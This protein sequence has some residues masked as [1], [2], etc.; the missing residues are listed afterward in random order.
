MSHSIFGTFVTTPLYNG[1][2]L[3]MQALPW[4]DLGVIVIVF[5]CVIRL[6][7]FPIAQKSVRTQLMVQKLQPEMDAIKEKYK[8]DKQEQAV[9]MMELYRNNK[10]N[11]FSN[12]LFLFIQIPIIFGLYFMVLRAGF[13]AIDPTFLYSFVDAP[14]HINTMFLGLVDVTVRSIPI[15][16]LAG[17]SQFFQAKLMRVP[18]TKKDTKPSFGN[19]FSKSLQFQMKYIFP[20]VI[21]F[22]A[23]ALPASV[24]LYWTTS[25]LFSIG[26]EWWTRKK[27][28][29]E[30]QQPTTNN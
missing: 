19:E 23:S 13:P 16:I 18:E 2:V 28:T 6:I 9:K 24:A 15:A 4:A 22:I 30:N 27:I 25:N 10:V 21:V 1:I 14:S 5:T 11:P 12:I 26:Q 7:L 20:V 8:N 17:V 29:A 3:L